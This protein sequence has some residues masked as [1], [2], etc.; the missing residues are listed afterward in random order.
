MYIYILMILIIL[1][2]ICLLSHGGIKKK[3]DQKIADV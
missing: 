1:Y 3:N 2:Y